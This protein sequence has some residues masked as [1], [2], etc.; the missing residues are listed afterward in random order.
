MK[1]VKICIGSA[2]HLKGSYQVIEVFK[3]LIEEYKLQDQ[4]ELNA[5]FCVG[6]CTQAVSVMRWDGKLLSVAKENARET[7]I[8][9]IMACL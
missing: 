8:N 9:E 3:G 7:F 6:N 1:S 4:I 5:A 2:C